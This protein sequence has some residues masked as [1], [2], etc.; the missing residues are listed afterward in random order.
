MRAIVCREFGAP[1]A[2]EEQ[3]APQPGPGQL[4]VA[5]AAAGLNYVD[6]L[7]VRGEYQIKPPLPFVPGSEISGTVASVGE[8]VEPNRYPLEDAARA[9][10]DLLNR[11]IN[12]KAVLIP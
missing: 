10:D 9:L 1:L 12:G 6:A 8:G 3:P 11:R 4:Q 7:F 5:V 2:L